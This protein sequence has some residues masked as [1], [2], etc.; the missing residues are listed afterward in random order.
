M[1]AEFRGK[2][3]FRGQSHRGTYEKRHG[4]AKAA[5][6]NLQGIS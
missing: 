3:A 5:A 1:A 2:A 4:Q 6:G